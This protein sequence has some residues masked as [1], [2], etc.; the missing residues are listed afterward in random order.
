MD[1]F[2]ILKK[3]ALAWGASLFGC[4]RTETLKKILY[5]I[6]SELKGLDWVLSIGV[7]LSRAVL[8]GIESEPTLLYKWHYRQANILLD[9]IAF[10]I[11]N[12][13]Q[14]IGGK[15]LP[16]PASQIVDWKAQ[17]GHL[18]HKEAVVR[19]GLGWIGRNNLVVNPDYGSQ[20]RYVTVLT[21]LPLAESGVEVPFG[22]GDCRNCIPACPVGALG[23]SPADYDF[24]RCFSFCKHVAKELNF[25][26]YICGIC[27]KACPG[28]LNLNQ[29]IANGL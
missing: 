17:R 20:V 24:D 14:K 29:V 19:S 13:I 27:V 21:D 1:N 8:D 6:P 18:S 23:E 22:C 12:Q 16:I 26:L 7:R 4:C 5:L 9:R 28:N 3:A 2:E 11:S 25:N 10:S 15:A